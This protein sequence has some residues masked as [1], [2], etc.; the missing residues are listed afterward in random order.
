MKTNKII[1]K[2]KL[3]YNIERIKVEGFKCFYKYEF[4]TNQ[5][6][7]FIDNFE[8]FGIDNNSIK[9]IAIENLVSEFKIALNNVIY[10]DPAGKEY[11]EYLENEKLNKNENE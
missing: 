5:W 1:E 9:E 3:S 10:G 4:S 7:E 2:K 11:V 6:L 8:G